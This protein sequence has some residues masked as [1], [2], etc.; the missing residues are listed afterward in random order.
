M[1]FSLRWE[2]ACRSVLTNGKN[3]KFTTSFFQDT[4]SFKSLAN[5][6]FNQKK[7]KHVSLSNSL[8][9]V[10]MELN[11]DNM[12]KRMGEG[13]GGWGIGVGNQEVEL[14]PHLACFSCKEQ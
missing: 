8:K 13:E 14:S 12:K 10:K 1:K 4:I 9:V 7:R 5:L 11:N 3:P 2:W 6:F